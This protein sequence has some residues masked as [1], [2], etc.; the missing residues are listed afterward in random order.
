MFRGSWLHVLEG[1]DMCT[2]LD[3]RASAVPK[4]KACLSK[5]IWKQYGNGVRPIDAPHQIKAS[6]IP[7]VS[8]SCT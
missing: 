4:A 6:E 5:I 1:G 2:G 8:I 7:I 3:G